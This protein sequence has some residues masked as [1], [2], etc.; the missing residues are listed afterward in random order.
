MLSSREDIFST[1]DEASFAAALGRHARIVRTETVSATGR[2]LFV[3]ER[4]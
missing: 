3:Y 2:R 1:Y 4:F